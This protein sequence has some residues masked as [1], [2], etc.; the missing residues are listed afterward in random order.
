[1]DDRSDRHDD[2]APLHDS[3]SAPPAAGSLADQDEPGAQTLSLDAE[4]LSRQDSRLT[5]VAQRLLDARQQ[6][7]IAFDPLVFSSPARDML[8]DLFVA[9]EEGRSV[10]DAS[11]STGVPQSAALRW[12][13]HLKQQGVIVETNRGDVNR[14]TSL[15]LTDQA[16]HAIERYLEALGIPERAE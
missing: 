10:L 8:L 16:S 6:W 9:G 13:T 3:L 14:Q 15:R 5:A 12:L 11:L 2:F 4:R 7:D 1:M